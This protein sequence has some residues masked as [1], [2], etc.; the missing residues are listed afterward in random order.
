M[1]HLNTTIFFL[2]FLNILSAQYLTP[3]WTRFQL[4]RGNGGG[5]GNLPII[6]VDSL[7]NVVVCGDTYHPG[8]ILGFITTKY[9]SNGVFL[10]EQRYDQ[11]NIDQ[12]N[13]AELSSTDDIYVGGNSFNPTTYLAEGKLFKYDTDGNLLWAFNYNPNNGGYKTTLSNIVV[14]PNQNILVLGTFN[15]PLA[16][17]SGSYVVCI[18]PDGSLLWSKELMDG[19][20]FTMRL[21][22]SATIIWGIKEGKFICW[23][24][25]ENGEI[26]NT[27]ISTVIYSDFFDNDFHVD[28]FGNLYIG[29][30][31]GEYKLS[32]FNLNAELDWFYTKP[33][34]TH[35]D[36]GF[37]TARSEGINS[38][39]L[40]NVF[41]SG[42]YYV[43]S[44]IGRV[45]LTSQLN[46]S[47]ELQWEHQV[48]FNNEYFISDISAGVFADSLYICTGSYRVDPLVNN[49]TYF[50][51]YYNKNGFA[52]GG[53]STMEG[54]KNSP[55]NLKFDKQ[56]VFVSGINFDSLF[57]AK[58]FVSK[59]KNPIISTTTQPATA[60]QPLSIY[61][62]PATQ[63]AWINCNY[64][65]KAATG[66]IEIIDHNGR[67][68]MTQWIEIEHSNT[69]HLAIKGV[70]R[71]P[72]GTYGI[73][74]RVGNMVYA[75]QLIKI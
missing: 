29:D 64:E 75:G 3:E 2:F 27:A 73:V 18:Q 71:L 54:L 8:P 74:L 56:N 9:D 65:G 34:I 5:P 4:T 25:S 62:N 32:K 21:T 44:I 33:Y 17:Q 37:V 6:L 11:W 43:D 70:T 48:L 10:W 13:A 72:A 22:G 60:V 59:Y 61:P 39:T 69:Q 41:F 40:G 66:H 38:D 46:Q 63:M 57:Y 23:Q 58:Q 19:S 53:I 12:I 67:V 68:V 1:K 26:D 31:F 20:A 36:P 45:H 15:N 7:Q 14:L 28:L 30:A 51:A 49:Y 55:R 24:I 52:A 47:G 50:I 16:A 42:V 35:P